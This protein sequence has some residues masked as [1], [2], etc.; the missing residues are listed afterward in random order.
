MCTGQ[1]IANLRLDVM[2]II[3]NELVIDDPELMKLDHPLKVRMLFDCIETVAETLKEDF[4][5][6]FHMVFV[7]LGKA[8]LGE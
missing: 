7:K 3:F 2:E 4:P 5:D 8:A 1:L 6:E